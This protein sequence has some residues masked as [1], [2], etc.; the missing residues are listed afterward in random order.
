[1]DAN[2]VREKMKDRRTKIR[3]VFFLGISTS[4]AADIVA[5]LVLHVPNE[6]NELLLIYILCASVLL[7]SI[8]FFFWVHSLKCPFCHK[9]FNGPIFSKDV[10][11]KNCISCG[12][13][14]K[15]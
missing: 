2:I 1:V 3:K 10:F 15:D 14:G 12:L 11:R 13:P 6:H 8:G 7:S 4:F 9:V 5:A